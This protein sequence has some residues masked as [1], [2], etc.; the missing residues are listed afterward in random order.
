[1]AENP[2]FVAGL[3]WDEKQFV[4][5]FLSEESYL[6]TN[7]ICVKIG[8]ELTLRG[9]DVSVSPQAV[10][11]KL[12]KSEL[13]KTNRDD[14]KASFRR[15][16]MEE[17]LAIERSHRMKAQEKLRQARATLAQTENEVRAAVTDRGVEVAAAEAASIAARA[18]MEKAKDNYEAL[19]KKQTEQF[20]TAQTT[21]HKERD[22][23]I[24]EDE[25]RWDNEIRMIAEEAQTKIAKID[26]EAKMS[27]RNAEQ[28]KAESVG[29]LQAVYGERGC[30]LT[31]GY[32]RE[33]KAADREYQMILQEATKEEDQAEENI[34]R[35]K[36]DEKAIVEGQ[37]WERELA[38]LAGVDVSSPADGSVP[39]SKSPSKNAA[40]KRDMLYNVVLLYEGG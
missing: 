2:K 5:T 15:F 21:L 14:G 17:L 28:R 1:M 20:E 19:R 38:H 32:Q 16:K 8:A 22:R 4:T 10:S 12:Q 18:K 29:T 35:V 34:K 13:V 39:P 37:A 36:Y 27:K 30:Q 11:A 25:A 7:E 9:S 6:A 33:W 24:A 3:P 23:A 26:E 31:T 40:G